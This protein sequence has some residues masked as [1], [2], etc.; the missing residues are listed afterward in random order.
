L[1]SSSEIYLRTSEHPTVAELPGELSI[2]TF[3]SLYEKRDDFET[4][5]REIIAQLVESAKTQGDVVYAVPG[6]PFVGESTVLGLKEKS[7]EEDF[8]LVVIPGVSFIEPCLHLLGVDALDGV[9][10]ADA[11]ELAGAHH[12]PFSPDQSVLIAQV[13]S[14][15]VAADVKLTLLNQYPE[16]HPVK[17][18]HAAGTDEAKIESL[19]LFEIDRDA[20][21]TSLTTLY[22]PPLGNPS[23]FESFQETVA[24]LRAPDG[25]PWDREQTHQTLRMH[26]MEECYEALQAIDE[27]DPDALKEELG[28]ITLQIVL[29][30]QIAT[31]AGHFRMADVISTINDKI[32][33]RHP[34]VFDDVEL[35]GVPDVLH[36]WEALKA[37]EREEEGN[38]KGLLEG[39]PIGLPALTQANELQSRAARVG[40]DWREI[41]GVIEKMEE[42]FSELMKADSDSEQ[43]SELG[44]L[45]FTIVNYARW[46]G[47]DPE[48]ALRLANSRF[49]A[50]FARI[51]E[52]AKLEGKRLSEMTLEQ[53]DS[54][55][56]QAK[57]DQE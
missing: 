2:H 54:V 48:S 6:D 29:N 16:N 3:D 30:A 39:V 5:Y 36:N 19:Q 31:E 28:D 22:L 38:D 25:C 21:F 43:E 27:G 41:T 9:R 8:N 23:A 55:W 52:R 40:F 33:R 1:N 42:E 10:V 56:E 49:R 13:F 47:I 34:H 17:L 51:E 50:R 37:V 12:P 20:S 15:L 7:E 11:F 18:I 46:I 26:L 45:L 44:D 53:M 35:D 57:S 24:H 4:V 32:I 14:R